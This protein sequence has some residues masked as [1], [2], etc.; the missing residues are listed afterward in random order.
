MK[1]Q[2]LRNVLRSAGLILLSAMLL[3]GCK[4]NANEIKAIQ[5]AGVLRVAMYKESLS[6]TGETSREKKL[7]DKI[8]QALKVEVQT[9]PVDSI[10]SASTMLAD[11]EADIA[12]GGIPSGVNR[13]KQLTVSDGYESEAWYVVTERGDYSD[14]LAAFTGRTLGVSSSLSDDSLSWMVGDDTIDLGK[15]QFADAL[16]YLTSENIA[17]FVCHRDEAR[18]LVD[19]SADVQVQPMQNALPEEMVVLLRSDDDNFLRG[20]NTI[21]SQSQEEQLTATE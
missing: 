4:S 15:V 18:R 10:E 1:N 19:L 16:T 21:I 9:V 17:G 2:R 13:N 11:K 7:A 8:A 12:I 3:S 5:K 14:S 20:I 6:A